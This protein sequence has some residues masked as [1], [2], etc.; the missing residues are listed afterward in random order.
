[1]TIEQLYQWA[2]E[3]DAL[4][5]EILVCDSYGDYTNSIEPDIINYIDYN[6]EVVRL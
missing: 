5:L 4:D 1:M 6:R 3:N 2:K